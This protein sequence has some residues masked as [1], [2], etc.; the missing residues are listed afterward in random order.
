MQ[1]TA[2]LWQ[3]ISPYFHTIMSHPFIVELANG[4][5][6]QERFEFYI[7]QDVI[8]LMGLTKVFS[9]VAHRAVESR[10]KEQFVRYAS[11]AE[12][13]AYA[14]EKNFLG[15]EIIAPSIS[16]TSACAEYSQHLL[17]TVTSASFEESVA[18]LLPCFWI[19]REVAQKLAKMAGAENRY[20]PWIALNAQPDYT[21]M[22]DEVITLANEIVRE[23]TQKKI[24][25][26]E[27]TCA[28]S[29]HF[30][31]RF[32]DEAYQLA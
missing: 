21:A 2:R 3:K 7:K 20:L 26:M 18:A 11:D 9:L 32:W 19:Y 10:I 14:L 30:E 4:T 5:L 23:G 17:Q 28:T 12:A 27:V 1:L 24:R 22:A 13:T 6:R 31:V 29:A 15:G 8:Y 16:A 25:L